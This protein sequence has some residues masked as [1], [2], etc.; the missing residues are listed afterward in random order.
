MFRSAQA[1]RRR[2]A[3]CRPDHF[4]VV[5]EINPWMSKSDRPDRDLVHKQWEG[6]K[7]A[8]EEAGATTFVMPPVPGL[9]DMVFAADLGIVDDNRF[10]RAA[11]RYAERA[12]E[13]AGA[14]DWLSGNEFTEIGPLE[15][16]LLEG[17]DI[18][19]VRRPHTDLRARPAYRDFRTP[20]CSPSTSECGSCP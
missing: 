5:F 10:L 6:L 17:G 14:A 20:A 8:I 1:Y 16:Y 4:D 9:A 18:S 19:L 7:A 2:F 3:L 12:P 11:F 15:G 13:A